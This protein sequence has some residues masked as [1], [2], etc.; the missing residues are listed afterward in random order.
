MSFEER[1]K[2]HADLTE[3]RLKELLTPVSHNG[4]Y[5]VSE[6]LYE[7]MR[8]STLG[9]G[10]RLRAFL[11]IQFC[12]ANGGQAENAL[13]YACAIEMM[14]AFSLIHDDLPA[15]DDDNM[16]RGKPSNHVKYGEA[17]AILAGDAL[18]IDSLN[19]VLGNRKCT[20]RQN[21]EA[22]YWLSRF[23]GGNGM[24]SGQQLDIDGEGK[25]LTGYEID[26][27]VGHKT[28]GMFSAA[29][30]M[31]TVAAYK[32]ELTKDE[33]PIPFT[34]GHLLGSAFQITDDLL[35]IYSTS[36]EMGKTVG[37]DEKS[38]KSTYVSLLGAEN[39][40]KRAENEIKIAKEWLNKLP[41]SVYRDELFALCD[42]VL[43]RRN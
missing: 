43:T 9:G 11:V 33:T 12:L 31:G 14:H 26:L 25:D 7:A 34:F 3:K 19:T 20:P 4:G 1:L 16:R 18:A 6:K 39:A 29:C 23:A 30:Y 2:Q 32:R 37:K 36:E 21:A 22:A 28:G 41:E 8:Y 15:M 35:D 40:A 27:L 5:N 42:Y 10:K 13:D 24:V 17:T 38:G